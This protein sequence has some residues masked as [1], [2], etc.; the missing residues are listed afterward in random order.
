VPRDGHLGRRRVTRL[1][2]VV[3][4]GAGAAG[5]TAVDTLRREGFSGRL[6]V[7]GA[8]PHRP[9]DRPPLSKQV[10]S[11]QWE[12][13]RL[14]LRRDADLAVLEVCWQLGTPATG[15]DVDVRRVTTADG[16]VHGYDGLVIATGVAPRRLSFGHELDGVHVLHT[17]D[18]LSRYA[19]ACA[20]RQRWS[21]SAR[22][23]WAAKW[24]PWPAC[25]GSR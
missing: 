17:V 10:L 12:P 8:E 2:H 23:S 18:E 25:S 16:L 14:A 4:V 7:L 11:G 15:L 3:V 19:P 13:D 6:T 9:Y 22:A 24:P 5:L 21:W 1:E 20:P